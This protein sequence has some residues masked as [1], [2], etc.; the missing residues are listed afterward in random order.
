MQTTAHV[1]PEGVQPQRAADPLV[2]RVLNGRFRVLEPIGEGGMGRVY[3][4]VQ[5]PLERVVALKVLLPGNPLSKEGGFIQRF[6]REA[7]LTARLNHPNTVTVIDYGQTEDGVC[8]IAMEYLQGR[9][10]FQALAQGPL[11]W[12]R[13]VEIMRQVCLSLR[14]AH[15]L[16][17][18]HR[19]L[20][21]G[22][23]MLLEAGDGR[24]H[25]K[26]L[27]F[28]L[29]KSLLPEESP[30]PVSPSLTRTGLFLGSPLY[31]APEQA[32]NATD[33]RSDIYSLG[34]TAFH[35]LAGRPPFVSQDPL[36]LLFAHHKLEPPRLREVRADLDV[37]PAVEQVLRRCL[38]KQPE[39]RYGSMDELLEALRQA[40]SQAGLGWVA[41]SGP[42]PALPPASAAT[43]APGR[44]E[45]Q[46]LVLD[47]KVEEP[48]SSATREPPRRRG[49]LWGALVLLVALCGLGLWLT[50]RPPPATETQ[51]VAPAGL[52]PAPAP[53]GPAREPER[54]PERATPSTVRFHITSEPPGARVFWKGA[55]WGTTPLV[56]EVQPQEQGLATA[57]LTLA[58]GGYQ[59]DHTT[60]GGSG[61]VLVHR[62]LVRQR[63]GRSSEAGTALPH[64][65]WVELRPSEPLSA[66]APAAEAHAPGAP[67]P[68]SPGKGVGP[69]NL[70]EGARPPAEL[71]G[72]VW[73]E[74]PAE[75]RTAGREG[76][77]ILKIVITKEGRV[78]EVKLLR[79]EEP[80]ASAAMAAVRE[81]RYTPA[82]LEG[83]PLSVYR[84]VRMPFRLR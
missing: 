50:S 51:S 26:V 28:G 82:T 20:K 59:T 81:W 34:A 48:V 75:A 57:E 11:P 33:L 32:R 22:N 18:V 79:G 65:E 8:F 24:D 23:I 35:M 54:E 38:Q 55:E 42:L 16:G 43:L 63:T 14:E 46:T 39:A 27:D 69:I 7:A 19:D 61:E 37:P 56:L 45:P 68:P 41:T 10:L 25:V 83:R 9:T 52:A 2:G 15:H 47:V 6:D 58:L 31:M 1:H 17:L 4:A 84:I 62:K 78:G 64:E 76:L 66:V 13:G 30:T 29:V 49:A 60:A 5:A 40:S 80:F 53:R 70:P 36:E 67:A 74:F 77:V 3:K 71:P 21:P 72:N 73:P 44:V 12:A